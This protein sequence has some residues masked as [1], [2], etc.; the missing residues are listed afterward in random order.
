MGLFVFGFYH[1]P[2]KKIK[3]HINQFISE[4]F[5]G[6]PDELIKTAHVS[7]LIC[8]LI[9]HFGEHQYI[10]STNVITGGGYSKLK[11]S[12]AMA[13]FPYLLLEFTFFQLPMLGQN[14]SNLT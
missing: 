13:K 1:Q 9:V 5:W 10:V 4:M 8:A 6:L 3:K 2:Y 14:Q 7:P 11:F 12:F